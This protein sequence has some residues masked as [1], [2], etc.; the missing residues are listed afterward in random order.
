[1][2][3]SATLNS[4]QRRIIAHLD[5]DAFFASVEERDK[6]YL[7]GSPVIVGADP[8]GGSGRGVVSTANYKAREL[9]IGSAL[10]IQKAWEYCR[11]STSPCVF[12]TP[13]MGKYSEVS[14]D[15]FAVI[16]KH[17][18]DIEQV[19]V[20]EAFF[21]ISH[22]GSFKKA[23]ALAQAIKKDIRKHT[24]LNCSIGIAPNKLVAK[25]ASDF[26]KPDGLTVVTPGRVEKFLAPMPIRVI[27]GIGKQAAAKLEKLGVTTVEDARAL[28]WQRM[29]QL[30][31]KHGF[32]M[33]ERLR[34]IDEREVAKEK[35]ARK[36]IGKHHTFR[37]DT[38]EREKVLVVLNDQAETIIRAMKKKKFKSF[39]TVVL[40]VRFE[41]FATV[42]RSLTLDEPGKTVKALQLKALK[43]VLPFFEKTENPE[44][45]K[46]RLVGLRIERLR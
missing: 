6:P 42:S 46:I 22:A 28:S 33:W 5:M 35:V 29:Q 38:D 8:K 19:S 40:T 27:L 31:G 39:Q 14:K 34:G 9:G 15:V 43:L 20:D 1:M 18:Q 24:K 30:F 21:D 16:K 23:E 37:E 7:K 3:R 12:I 2:D 10:P 32:S 36:S 13:H 11:D 45:K 25:I 17:V 44:N 26:G 41:D 4:M